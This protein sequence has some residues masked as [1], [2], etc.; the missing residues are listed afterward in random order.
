MKS[1]VVFGSNGK[2]SLKDFSLTQ[3]TDI[4]NID[5]Y[6]AAALKK[7][8]Q[9]FLIIREAKT[10]LLDVIELHQTQNQLGNPV[11]NVPVAQRL[12]FKQG[13]ATIKLL[14]V[15][16]ETETY[17][18]SGSASAFL[19]ADNYAIARETAIVRELGTNVK[20]YYDAIVTVLQEVIEKGEKSE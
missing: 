17:H 8:T 14:I 2:L 16:T 7:P 4:G 11:F 9:V 20:T 12:K 10:G 18:F 13:N 6:V 15:D 5:F 3:P 1:T 19:T